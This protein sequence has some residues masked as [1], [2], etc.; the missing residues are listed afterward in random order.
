MKKLILL[1]VVFIVGCAHKPPSATFYVGMTEKE[2]I[3]QNNLIL[4][5]E[6]I[7]KAD[8]ITGDF[9][10]VYDQFQRIDYRQMPLSSKLPEKDKNRVL[11]EIFEKSSSYY[12]S[13]CNDTLTAVY[14]G[15]W[16]SVWE[17]E[18]DYDKYATP[19]L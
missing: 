5:E 7:V 14:R 1:F 18:I 12:F 10:K 8:K 15:R 4:N 11:Y 2:F 6:N 13:F 9:V 3:Q 17:K 19:P 16:N